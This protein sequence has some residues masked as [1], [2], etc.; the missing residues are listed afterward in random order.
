MKR[1]IPFLL[2]LIVAMSFASCKASQQPKSEILKAWTGDFSE[3]TLTKT[4]KKYK[5]NISPLSQK[6]KIRF[7]K[8]PLK[9]ILKY[10]PVR[11]HGCPRWMMRTSMWNEKDI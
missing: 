10:H 6:A 8:Y 9:Q 3:E 4:I 7:R 1:M 11:F 2:A 5:R